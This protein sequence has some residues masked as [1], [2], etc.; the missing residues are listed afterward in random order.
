MV[1]SPCWRFLI[2]AGSRYCFQ[3]C[4][5][6]GLI[7]ALWVMGHR[8]Q[9]GPYRVSSFRL[10][11]LHKQDPTSNQSP[12]IEKGGWGVSW[13]QERK[14][15]QASG[16]TYDWNWKLS[17]FSPLI[18]Q[19]LSGERSYKGIGKS[20][21]CV[22]T[23]FPEPTLPHRTLPPH[24]PLLSPLSLFKTEECSGCVTTTLK[25]SGLKHQLFY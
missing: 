25:I 20:P 16:R 15:K 2:G 24:H 9:G 3:G 14:F 10:F 1:L 12:K 21:A 8:G 7:K 5:C 18:C 22:Y 17:A 4:Q 23:Y 13:P 6:H 11:W 19:K